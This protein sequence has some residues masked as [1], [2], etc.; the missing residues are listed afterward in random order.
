MYSLSVREDHSPILRVSIL[1]VYFHEIPDLLP[2]WLIKLL[3]KM[4]YQP[5]RSSDQR[6]PATDDWPKPEFGNRDLDGT[7]GVDH[8]M[9]LRLYRVE[10][11]KMVTSQVLFLEQLKESLGAGIDWVVNGMADISD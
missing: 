6:A 1:D 8:Q 11:F 9:S 7:G 5:S 10:E 3:A 4:T 2:H